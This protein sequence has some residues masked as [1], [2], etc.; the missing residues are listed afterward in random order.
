MTEIL[1][2]ARLTI[3]ELIRS[4]VFA[5]LLLVIPLIL[6]TASLLASVTMGS[7]EEIISDL[8][9]AS[10][11]ILINLL[12][13]VQTIQLSQ[14]E[15]EKRTLYV[16]LPRLT[17]RIYFIAGKFLGLA[18]AY[19]L[20]TLISISMLAITVLMFDWNQWGAFLA[21]TT[22][23]LFE[24]WIVIAIAMLF[25]NATSHFLA[26][27][28]TLMVNIAGRFVDT[29]KAFGDQLGG[30]MAL[31]TDTAALFLPNLE[32]LNLRNILFNDEAMTVTAMDGLLLY[33]ITE[34]GMILSLCTLIY[35]RK[36]L[37]G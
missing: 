24:V 2:I 26:I 28:F 13:I 9:F 12:I 27:L 16:V 36:D 8:G 25:S 37:Q 21:V 20:L 4:K 34:T 22:S 31:L 19:S 32:V 6:A 10:I 11:T 7:T 18:S 33:T 14:Q 29:I 30:G 23:I 5:A 35:L 17:S 15:I 3:L 1:A